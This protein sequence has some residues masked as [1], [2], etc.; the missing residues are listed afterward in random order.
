MLDLFNKVFAEK[1][2]G[3]ALS[4]AKQQLVS[5][6]REAT[7]LPLLR[8]D[9]NNE[10]HCT[11]IYCNS[12]DGSPYNLSWRGFIGTSDYRDDG[13][14]VYGAHL[15]PLLDMFRVHLLRADENEDSQPYT[16]RYLMLTPEDG[17]KD[18]GW[19]VDEYG[20]FEHWYRKEAG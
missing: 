8:R 14:F 18:L 11:E 16:F 7:G 12:I 4:D 5:S 6:L 19:Q 15:F 17:W 20:E 3:T 1:L 13:M 10:I 9:D 2:A